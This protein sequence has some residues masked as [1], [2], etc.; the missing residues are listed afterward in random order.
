M[1]HERV[2]K[3]AAVA[4]LQDRRL[5]FDEPF[6]IE[7]RAR[8]PDHPGPQHRQLT[9]VLVHEQVQIAAAVPR[10][11]VGDAVEGVGKWTTDLGEHRHL[12]D[13]KRRLAAPRLHRR[14]RRADDVTEIYVRQRDAVGLA[15]ELDPARTVDQVEEG[16]LPVLAPGHD[17]PGEASLLVALLVR[18]EPLGLGAHGRDLVPVRKSLRQHAGILSPRHSSRGF[19]RL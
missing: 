8:G 6:G 1:G 11:D 14:A 4:R 12:V 16:Q 7:V 2:R 19:A 15:E 17:A 18:L 5:H 9:R 13:R 10:L 3:R